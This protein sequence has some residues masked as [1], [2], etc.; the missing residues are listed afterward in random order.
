METR[1]FQN[2]LMWKRLEEQKDFF[3]S[4]Y[5][6]KGKKSKNKTNML[7]NLKKIWDPKRLQDTRSIKKQIDILG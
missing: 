4:H 6:G 5:K 2:R 3:L 1:D 7:K